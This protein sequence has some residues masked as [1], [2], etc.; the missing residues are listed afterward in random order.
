M[1]TLS[2][3]M[4]IG[5]TMAFAAGTAGAADAVA[6][7]TVQERVNPQAA[8]VKAFSDRVN[9][10]VELRKK[11][12]ASLPPLKETKDPAQLKSREQALG[13]AIRSARADAKAG[14]VFGDDVR[15]LFVRL[16]REDW[17]SRTHRERAAAMSEVP[18]PT[19][20]RPRVNARYPE[21][22][23][24]ATM[25]P[26]LLAKLQRLPDDVEYRFVGRHLVLRDVKANLIVDVLYD[27]L[28][29]SPAT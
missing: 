3:A 20:V 22:V 29:P 7:R 10:Y 21:G 14:D 16:V 1:T 18:A 25:P 23:P 19:T 8:Q 24:L 27:V 28:P 2:T 4:A 11:V 26:L 13:E 17:S 12:E 15:L 5:W 6:D 9:Q